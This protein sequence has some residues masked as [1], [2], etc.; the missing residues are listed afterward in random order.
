LHKKVIISLKDKH[1]EPAGLFGRDGENVVELVTEGNYYKKD[2]H[3]Y[4]S[5]MESEVTGME[6]TETTLEISDDTLTIMRQGTVNSQLI[7]KKGEKRLSHYDT[8]QGFFTVGLYTRDLKIDIDDSG[9][10]IC[11]DY[12]IEIDN[13]STGSNNFCMFIREAGY[14]DGKYHG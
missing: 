1:N 6:G 3:Y 5:Y 7:F 9:G 2:G 10:S 11:V 13:N 8:A 12:N 4:I 14:T